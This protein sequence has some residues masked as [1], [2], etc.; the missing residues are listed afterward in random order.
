MCEACGLTRK[1]VDYD[2]RQGLIH[3][4]YAEHGY[5]NFTEQDLLLAQT[6]IR[7]KRHARRHRLRPP[8]LR[9]KASVRTPL[10]N[11]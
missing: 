4:R 11:F 1:A 8:R 10:L 3:P 9:R 5:R 2:E 6:P 7:A